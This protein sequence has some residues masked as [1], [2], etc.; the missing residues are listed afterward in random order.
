MASVFSHVVAGAAI[1]SAGAAPGARVRLSVAA[2]VCAMVPDLDLFG[3]VVGVPWG[4]MLGHRG[5]THSLAFA[6]A[7]AALVVAG[8]FDTDRFAGSRGR[9]WLVLFVATASHG[10]LDAMTDGGSGVAFFAPVDSTR[11]FLPWRPIPVSPIGV[12]RFF[13]QRGATIMRAE[14]VLIWLP[15]GVL[16]LAAAV[17]RRRWR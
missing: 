1:G 4:H 12:S 17:L 14:I 15:S 11:Y 13:T 9:L 2:A 5:L 7:L 16:A 8:W 6:A 3:L 10:V